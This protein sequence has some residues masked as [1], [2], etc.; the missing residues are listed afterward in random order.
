MRVTNYISKL[1]IQFYFRN[2]PFAGK[3]SFTSM[4]QIE[5]V[6]V[7][8]WWEIKFRKQPKLSVCLQLT[9][10]NI[11]QKKNLLLAGTTNDA[12]VAFSCTVLRVLFWE[13]SPEQNCKVSFWVRPI[14][15]VSR[16]HLL[17]LTLKMPLFFCLSLDV[18]LLKM[19]E[20]TNYDCK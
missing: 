17:P 16:L 3:S 14:K 7:T 5:I 6:I 20:I 19:P 13:I 18:L 11:N 2:L 10:H 12:F 4:R 8:H 1:L 15:M 9:P